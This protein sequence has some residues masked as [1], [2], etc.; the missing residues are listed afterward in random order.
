VN[1]ING[2]FE[3][4]FL[5][6]NDN[7]ISIKKRAAPR[8]MNIVWHDINDRRME[9]DVF[10]D[11]KKVKALFEQTKPN[12]PIQ[13][14]ISIDRNTKPRETK[15]ISIKLKTADKEID[16]QEAIVSQETYTKSVPY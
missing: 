9:S 14:V 15:G 1:Y 5:S 16:L 2:E 4:I 11:E 13:F 6:L 3:S 8:K 7:R 10:F 12:E